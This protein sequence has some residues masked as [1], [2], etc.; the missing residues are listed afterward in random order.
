MKH[1]GATLGQRW[2]QSSIGSQMI[3]AFAVIGV[4]AIILN[5]ALISVLLK[6]FFF[7][8]QGRQMIAQAQA[9]SHC[10]EEAPALLLHTSPQTLND[11]IQATLAASPKRHA[12]LLN[13]SGALVY[14]SPQLSSS[15][16][17]GLL[18]LARS[19]LA[20]AVSSG[21]SPESWVSWQGQL[22]TDTP[23]T[24]Q[25]I[26]PTN[27]HIQT[28]Q[29]V[30]ELLLAESQSITIGI[31][32]YS[33]DPVLLTAIVTLALV[34]LGSGLAARWLARPLRAM[35][36]TAHAIA[37]GDYQ[38][39]VTP[40]GP[41]EAR[42]LSH[43]FNQMVDT[44]LHQQRIE[45][46]LIAN[47]SHE[48]AAPLGLI[49]GYAE[50]LL[51]GVISDQESCLNAL[52]AISAETTRLGRIS[53]DLLDLALLETR[54]ITMHLEAVPIAALLTALYKRFLIRAGQQKVQ[55]QLDLAPHLPVAETDGLRLEQVLVNLL[56]NALHAT[57]AGDTITIG[58]RIQDNELRLL[59]ADTGKGIPAE[60]L[61]R[62]WERFS[63][64]EERRDRRAKIQGASSVG[65]GLAVCRS[66][67]EL[68]GGHIEVESKVR[69][70][71]TFTIGL[72][73]MSRK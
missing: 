13:A 46:D 48:L 29:I 39:R 43:S 22:I 27:P 44:V 1:V 55:I 45:R 38:Q 12:L 24:I 59:V 15:Q 10:C 21:V 70:G 9:L 26:S 53:S 57:E 5:T 69:Q 50:A 47:V 30:G 41:R 25:S 20:H 8:R 16:Q 4:I 51:D 61:A 28:T 66:I 71:T 67:V 6:N 18:T 40:A 52:Q 64:G 54:Q 37:Q 23:I 17:A 62:I 32:R 68:L 36:A 56:N 33:L 72:P 11:L 3:V 31:W 7:E 60:A 19:D 73:L 42:V 2:R 63:R 35:T 14:A 34:L 65:L 49:R 58:A